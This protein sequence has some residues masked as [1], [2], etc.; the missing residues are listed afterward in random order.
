MGEPFLVSLISPY[1]LFTRFYFTSRCLFV[2]NKIL[3]AEKYSDIEAIYFAKPFFFVLII[4]LVTYLFIIPSKV[5]N[6]FCQ[7]VFAQEFLN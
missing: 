7:D 3:T 6:A 4:W 2:L 5:L 1:S